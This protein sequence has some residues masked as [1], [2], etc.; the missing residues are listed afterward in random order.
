MV[1]ISNI[2][3]ASLI[4]T[5]MVIIVVFYIFN[6]EDEEIVLKSYFK[7]GIYVFSLTILILFYYKKNIIDKYAYKPITA[8]SEVF[9][10]ITDSQQLNGIMSLN[11]IIDG[12][13]ELI[14]DN[15]PKSIT[16][17]NIV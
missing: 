10:E 15:I 2:L 12:G 9:T 6:T 4:I 11:S 3:I 14:I 1:L 16:C 5:I 7:L 8:A 13:D 17:N